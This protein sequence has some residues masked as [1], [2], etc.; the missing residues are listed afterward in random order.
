MSDRFDCVV[1]CMARLHQ[2]ISVEN[3][4]VLE[5]RLLLQRRLWQELQHQVE[6]RNSLVLA[7]LSRWTGF[8]QRCRQLMDAMNK[9]EQRICANHEF[10]IEELLEKLAKVAYCI[11]NLTCTTNN[12]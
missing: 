1:T 7:K 4:A 2:Y 8:S 10:S 6:M 11:L 12:V 5:E 3:V 9:L